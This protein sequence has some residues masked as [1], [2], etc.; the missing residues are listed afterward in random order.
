MRNQIVKLISKVL[1]ANGVSVSQQTIERTV[2]THPEYP[3]MQCISDSFDS[4]KVQHAVMKISLEKL[5][6]L[7]VEV[8]SLYG[9]KNISQ[10]VCF[11]SFAKSAHKL[12]ATK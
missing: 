2:L 1:K 5:R 9:K 8:I 4:W 6:E 3:S 12:I 10:P 11:K 7:D